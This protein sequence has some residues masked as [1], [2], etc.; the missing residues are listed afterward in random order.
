MR[1]F[2]FLIAVAIV[3]AVRAAATIRPPTVVATATRHSIAISS[4]QIDV[5][6]LPALDM[7]N[8]FSGR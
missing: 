6:S 2:S 3:I 8:L 1:M 4:Q 5:E 7:E